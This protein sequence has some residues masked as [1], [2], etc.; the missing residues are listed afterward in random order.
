MLI[1]GTTQPQTQPIIVALGTSW[2]KGYEKGRYLQYDALNPLIGNIRSYCES[3]GIPF[4]VDDDDK[5]LTHIN[6]ERAK[7]GKAGAKVVVLAGKDAVISD[8]F[9]TL[10]NDQ[11]NAF[12][13]G[14]VTRQRSNEWGNPALAR[15]WQVL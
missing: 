11:G 8:E 12:V 9:A 6:A 10:R 2:I 3:K 13:V 15:V 7:E 4:I 1:L 14:V 5:L